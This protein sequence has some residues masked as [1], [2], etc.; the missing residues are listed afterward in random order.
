LKKEMIEEFYMDLVIDRVRQVLL[1]PK[2]AWSA[3]KDETGSPTD[4]VRN[5]LI[6]LAAV[7]V[8]GFLIGQLFFADPRMLLIP[9]LIAA[10]VFYVLIFVATV[11]AAFIINSLALEFGAVADELAAFKL[12]A[13]SSTAP[14]LACGVFIFPAFSA[15][16]VLGFYGIYLFYT[17]VPV[18]MSC[19]QEKAGSYTVAAVIVMVILA[20]ITFGITL[21]FTCR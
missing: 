14:L 3:I 13:Y 6:Y 21:V 1:E 16:A 8:T 19:P 11:L 12:V 17:G 4:I 20:S 2:R 7:P 15:L 5:Y 9:G 18:L 10:V